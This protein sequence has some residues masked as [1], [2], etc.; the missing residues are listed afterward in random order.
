MEFTGTGTGRFVQR[1]RQEVAK[2]RSGRQKLPRGVE[3]GAST[4]SVC[5][6]WTCAVKR[7]LTKTT[8]QLVAR[9][10]HAQVGSVVGKHIVGAGTLGCSAS[11]GSEHARLT[12]YCIP[13]SNSSSSE[14]VRRERQ[15]CVCF[16]FAVPSS[17][18]CVCTSTS[19]NTRASENGVT[20][21]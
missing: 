9:R 19:S 2:H 10:T 15:G 6:M 4:P 11:H 20:S 13:V 17:I 21:V 5:Y 3:G 1:A 16:A 18:V 12:S 14:C 8:A 7:S